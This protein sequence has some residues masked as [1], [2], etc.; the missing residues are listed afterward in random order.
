M[1]NTR[2]S[3]TT[4]VSDSV[5][6][7]VDPQTAYERVGDVTQMGRWS[8][9]NTGAVLADPGAPVSAG[10]RFVGSNVRRGFR[11][12]TECVVTA[13][14]P[15]SRFAFAV[16]KFGIGKPL[17]PVAIATWEYRFEPVDGGTKVTEIWHDDRAKW[18]DAVVSI[19][20]RL[21]TGKRGFA[22]F[23]RGNIRRTLD[24]LKSELEA[25]ATSA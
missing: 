15:G 17:L 25:E 18:P 1:L 22:E 21:V 6:V 20:D 4:E 13:A 2:Q 19:Y 11:W 7:A 3:R 8:P 14:E 24:R 9:E 5:V 10:A 23:Q 12:Q 16:R